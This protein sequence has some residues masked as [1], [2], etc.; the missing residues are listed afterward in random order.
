MTCIQGNTDDIRS[1]NSDELH[2]GK[3][4]AHLHSGNTDDTFR[5]YKL[6]IKTYI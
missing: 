4:T 2:S 6:D 3:K 5:K 1:V